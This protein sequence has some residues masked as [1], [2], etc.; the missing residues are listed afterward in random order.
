MIQQLFLVVFIFSGLTLPLSFSS[1]EWTP[2]WK[3]DAAVALQPTRTLPLIPNRPEPPKKRVE[4]AGPNLS[5]NAG[6][7]FDRSS[8]TVLWQKEANVVMPIASLTKLMTAIVVLEQGP[9]WEQPHV[10]RRDEN[11]RGGAK[12]HVAEGDSVR[13]IDLFYASLVGSANNATLALARSTGLSDEAFVAEMNRKAK[14]LGLTHTRFVDPTGLDP[15]NV[16]NARELAILARAAFRLPEIADATTRL[17]HE[18]RSVARDEYHHLQTTNELL[19]A[20]DLSL[21]GSKTGYLDEAGYC[22]ISQVELGSRELIVVLL[23][24]KSHLQRF[25]ET[26]ELLGWA[27]ENFDFSLSH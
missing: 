21:T 25:Q 18:L 10:M 9:N 4:D 8:G 19:K 13:Q 16:S 24:A 1:V 22:L 7:M 15:L 27:S 14:A 11:D 17:N 5:S 3:R 20:G 12:L 23:G 26:R 2:T 6:L